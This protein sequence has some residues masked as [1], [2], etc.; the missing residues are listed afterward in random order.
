MAGRDA[1]YGIVLGPFRGDGDAQTVQFACYLGFGGRVGDFG[2][3]ILLIR[4][5][6]VG[7]SS[8]PGKNVRPRSGIV[9][10]FAARHCAGLAG[11][12]R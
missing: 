3:Q 2:R 11:N 12:A 10:G 8:Q 1:A 6:P 4:F 7:Y 5:Q 9:P